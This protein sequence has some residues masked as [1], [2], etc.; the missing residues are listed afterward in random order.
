MGPL[1]HGSQ[2]PKIGSVSKRQNRHWPCAIYLPGRN[3]P[4]HWRARHSP[5]LFARRNANCICQKWWGQHESLHPRHRGRHHSLLHI[6]RR[7]LTG[8]HPALVARWVTNRILVLPQRH[9]AG[10]RHHSRNRRHLHGARRLPR[11]RPRPV[12]D[13]R[14]IIPRICL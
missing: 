11:N 12:L 8:C 5:G 7:R 4:Q 9:L 10:H 3:A 14:W 13:T 1:H 6:L 2:S